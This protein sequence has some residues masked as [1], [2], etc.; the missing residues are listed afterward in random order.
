MLPFQPDPDMFSIHRFQVQRQNIEYNNMMGFFDWS[1]ARNNFKT[2]TSG[3][4]IA[5]VGLERY[6]F[7]NGAQMQ[8][9]LAMSTDIQETKRTV[10]TLLDWFTD[11]GAFMALLLFFVQ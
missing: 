11:L 3:F 8:I 10:M 4:Q 2:V 1:G 6:P 5:Q 7:I 9:E